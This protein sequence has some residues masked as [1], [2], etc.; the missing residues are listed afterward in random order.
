M[1]KKIIFLEYKVP[2]RSIKSHTR[3]IRAVKQAKIRLNLRIGLKR[4]KGIKYKIV[5]LE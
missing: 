5:F 3:M 2:K 4:I 1:Y